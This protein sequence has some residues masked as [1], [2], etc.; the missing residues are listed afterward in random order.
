LGK[1]VLA[2]STAFVLSA[3]IV[4][5]G[6][7][8]AGQSET[9]TTSAGVGTVTT[10]TTSTT[11]TT[12]TV[13]VSTTTRVSAPEFESSVSSISADDLYAS[14]RE[15]CPLGVEDLRAVDVTFWRFDGTAHTGRLI[16]A[17]E[18]TEDVIG[19]MADLFEA[20]FPIERMEPVD[21]F[22]GDDDLSMAANNTSAFNCRPITGG[23][24]WS[25]HSYGRAI[26]INPV[27][28]PYVHGG[29][30]LPPEGS[31]YTDRSLDI[32]GMIHAGDAIVEAFSERGWVWG[33]TW[34]GTK[35]YQHFSTTGR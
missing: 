7:A 24:S 17:A 13:Y 26:D 16:V 31:R 6:A 1:Q 15:G 29:T 33:G 30:V 4:A 21:V 22:D 20:G 5:C 28:N 10:S 3:L 27:Q 12:T 9:T 32:P 18:L 8:P 2:S 34:S 35:D 14:W 19:I 25:E 23:S 11:A